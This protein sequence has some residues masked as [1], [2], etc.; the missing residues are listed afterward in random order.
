MPL[1]KMQCAKEKANILPLPT[2]PYDKSKISK[3]IDILGELIQRLDPD[4]Y[5]FKDK[6]MMAKKHWLT[7]WNITQAI[8][9]KQEKPEILY[10]MG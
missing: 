8:Y 4:D 6:V 9:Q 5:V 1:K 2:L 10:T 7:I 3:T